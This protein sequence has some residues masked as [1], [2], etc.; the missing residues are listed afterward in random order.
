M[1]ELLAKDIMTKKVITISKDA[2]LAELAKLLIK[3][4]ISG[5]PIVDKREELVGIVTEADLII[6]ESNLPFPLSFSFAFLESYES[7]TKSTKEY[8]ETRVEEVMSTNVKTARE[9]MPISKVVNIMINNNIN[10][11]PVLNND[12]KLT[13]IITRAD[14]IKSIIKKSEKK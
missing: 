8:L 2:T 12:G 11:L 10:R 4:K 3:N 13:G 6:K 5:V 9:D 1:A 7:Y 14:I